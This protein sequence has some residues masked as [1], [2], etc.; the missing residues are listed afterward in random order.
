MNIKKYLELSDKKLDA[1][2]NTYNYIPNEYEIENIGLSIDRCCLK[3]TVKIAQMHAQD[4]KTVTQ[5]KMLFEK[6]RLAIRNKFIWPG[7]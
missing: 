4:K 3:E 1:L 5:E 2:E 6:R 7:K